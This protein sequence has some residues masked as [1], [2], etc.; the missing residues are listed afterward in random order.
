MWSTKRA[1]NE[2][3]EVIFL[4]LKYMTLSSD[5]F[6]KGESMYIVQFNTG[7]SMNFR[8]VRHL[9]YFPAFFSIRIINLTYFSDENEQ[10]LLYSLVDW[11][12]IVYFSLKLIFCI[13]IVL[14]M[15]YVYF[16]FAF[17]FET[18]ARRKQSATLCRYL[19]S[20]F[21]FIEWQEYG[22]EFTSLSIV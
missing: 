14:S 18:E 4:F 2:R 17:F 9:P 6:S 8:Y 7:S 5:C 11:V 22:V 15:C 1:D 3:L 13:S 16:V 21:Y 10:Y 12:K 20:I 19:S